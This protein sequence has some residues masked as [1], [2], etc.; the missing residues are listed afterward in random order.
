MPGDGRDCSC[1]RCGCSCRRTG[2]TGCRHRRRA[3]PLHRGR[4]VGRGHRHLRGRGGQRG[5][6]DRQASVPTPT[7]GD[8]RSPPT[9]R[10]CL[11]ELDAD[12]RRTADRAGDRHDRPRT[13]S[14][15]RRPRAMT[16]PAAGTSITVTVPATAGHKTTRTTALA[17]RRAR[18]LVGSG[19]LGSHAT[20]RRLARVADSQTTTDRGHAAPR[21]RRHG[22]VDLVRPDDGPRRHRR[23]PHG[24]AARVTSGDASP[25]GVGRHRL[26]L[27]GRPP[28]AADGQRPDPLNSRRARVG[29]AAGRS[30]AVGGERTPTLAAR[31]PATAPTA[32]TVDGYASYEATTAGTSGTRTGPPVAGRAIAILRDAGFTDVTPGAHRPRRGPRRRRPTATGAP[33]GATGWW[34]ARARRP[35]DRRRHRPRP[36]R[37]CPPPTAEPSRR[38]P[39]RRPASGASACASSCC[40]PR[41]SGPRSGAS[42]TS[43]RRGGGQVKPA[44]PP[45]RNPA[46]GRRPSWRACG[47][48]RIAGSW[49]RGRGQGAR[50]RQGRP[51]ARRGDGIPDPVIDGV[52]AMAVIAPLTAAASSLSPAAGAAV[53]LVGRARRPAT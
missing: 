12:R 17:A 20:T 8:R 44:L 23:R 46:D 50:G 33:P 52:G 36:R 22:D 11:P 30:V 53:A 26:L 31:L 19:T 38:R 4:R 51:G 49:S 7:G 28:E 13:T 42:S 2:W 1:R 47:S 25:H 43:R 48:P 45:G 32:I 37:R 15:D 35:R 18:L 27:P 16:T 14:H 39:A 29:A 9:G 21:D 24:R 40:A 6:A 41:S 5:V 3:G 10:H 34:R